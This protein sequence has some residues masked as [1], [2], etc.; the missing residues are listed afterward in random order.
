MKQKPEM[1]PIAFFQ[2]RTLSEGFLMDFE[3]SLMLNW[4]FSAKRCWI[5]SVLSA[6]CAQEGKGVE[7]IECF[8]FGH[9]TL[10]KLERF[11][12]S[13]N[14]CWICVACC[15]CVI[16]ISE[17]AWIRFWYHQGWYFVPVCPAPSEYRPTF[18]GFF[19]SFY[20]I[21]HSWKSIQPFGKPFY[22]L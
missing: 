2:Y 15:D 10:W 17:H 8:V 4:T 19:F 14:T 1:Q 3:E 13:L 20:L 7:S 12:P 11:H 6:R 18:L 22:S 21:T 5:N 16:L 9:M